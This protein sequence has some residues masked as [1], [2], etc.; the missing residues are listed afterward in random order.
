[1][2]ISILCADLS[3][4]CL[5]RSYILARALE[6]KHDVEIVGPAFGAGIWEPLAGERFRYRAW[7]MS[8]SATSLPD[9]RRLADWVDGD[10]IYANKP[11]AA[12]YGVG[13]W[14]RLKRPRPLVLDIDDWDAAFVRDA[15]R[16]LAGWSR[17][18]YL[19]GSTLRPHLNHGLWNNLLFDSLTR[20]ADNRTVSNSFLVR[21]YG[22]TLV[23]HGR[24][25]DAF[26]PRDVDRAGL[27][28]RH[29]LG[30]DERLVAFLG[31]LQ[32]YKGVDDLV[33]A[34]EGLGAA[35]P[36]LLLVGVGDDPAS[37]STLETAKRRLNGRVHSF[38]PQRF[39]RLPEFLALADAAVV[40]QR[41]SLATLGQ[42][43]A[44]LFDAMALGIPTISTAVSDI[45]DVL[46]GAGWVVPPNSP[47]ALR[48]AIRERFAAPEEASRRADI[49]RRRCVE[50]F[51]WDAMA[52]DLDAVFGAIR[53][54]HSL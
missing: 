16:G 43:P 30:E 7:P 4:N 17:L 34:L 42:M 39:D 38:G 49:A 23:W 40:P 21:R 22:G 44:K 53:Q 18:R 25:T 32:P 5:G 15:L 48:E 31:T 27:R 37:R 29:G 52:R 14:A 1:L 6:R 19:L 36:A 8:R 11:L 20:F 3:G 46:G 2:K 10:V 28:R 35:A 12:S 47:D 45:P 33:E 13:L 9:L 51:S 50:R 41:E 54:R 24:D 26:R